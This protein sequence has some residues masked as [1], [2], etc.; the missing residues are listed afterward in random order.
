MHGTPQEFFGILSCCEP[1]SQ[2]DRCIQT[3]FSAFTSSVTLQYHISVEL[4]L[5]R[6][7]CSH[8]IVATKMILVPVW[9]TCPFPDLLSHESL[10]LGFVVFESICSASLLYFSLGSSDGAV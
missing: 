1:A 3:H 4:L 2:L 5:G 6:F 10:A 7:F 9:G 8:S